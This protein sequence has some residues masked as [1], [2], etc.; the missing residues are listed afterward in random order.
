MLLTLFSR[1]G[2][3]AWFVWWPIF[4]RFAITTWI[5]FS[6]HNQVK[7]LTW[8]IT[9]HFANC[10]L[11]RPIYSLLCHVLI[12]ILIKA[13]LNSLWIVCSQSL[14]VTA[15]LNK[16]IKL[17]YQHP[18]SSNNKYLNRLSIG[19][20]GLQWYKY[21]LSFLRPS[22]VCFVYCADNNTEGVHYYS[23]SNNTKWR[24]CIVALGL[25]CSLFH[26]IVTRARQLA[27]DRDRTIGCHD[28]LAQQSKSIKVPDIMKLW[29]P[30]W[31]QIKT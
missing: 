3:V 1:L 7:I 22:R 14:I 26:F 19:S 23:N 18:K 10:N 17:Y 13:W 29:S 9:L 31:Y 11:H 27:D 2:L 21:A 5:Q 15:E 20:T 28:G 30:W 25:G 16:K 8:W 12:C 6:S 4:Q 24:H